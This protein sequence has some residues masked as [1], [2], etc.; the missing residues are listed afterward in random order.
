MHLC[1]DA[2]ASGAD[3][4]LQ[5]RCAL[6]PCWPPRQAVGRHGLGPSRGLG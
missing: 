5:V 4:E 1:V 6:H 3:P 2:K